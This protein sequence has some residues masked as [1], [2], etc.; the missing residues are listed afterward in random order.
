M[1]NKKDKHFFGASAVELYLDE[2]RRG[3]EMVDALLGLWALH[4]HRWYE[5]R[6]L[7]AAFCTVV[8][9]ALMFLASVMFI[10]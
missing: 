1:D 10:N 9:V 7:I 6:E 5:N 2:Q 8:L 3:N 4:R